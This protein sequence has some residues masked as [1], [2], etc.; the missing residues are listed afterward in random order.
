MKPRFG[1]VIAGPPGSGKTTYCQA[2]AE[3]FNNIERKT[4]VVNLDPANE[5]YVDAETGESLVD[6]PVID[7]SEIITLQN[8]VDSFGL[9]PNGGLLYCMQYLETN[10]DWLVQK[11]DELEDDTYVL[12]DIPGQVE[13]T[14]HDQSLQN[15]LKHLT[16]KKLNWRLCCVHLVDA[17][18]CVDPGRYISALIVSL[19][20]MIQLELPHINVLSKIDLMEG[21][22][23]LSFS[24]EYYTRAVDLSYI[25]ESLDNN[26]RTKKFSNLNKALC[27]IVEEFGLVGF[28]TLCIQ[29]KRS[30]VTLAHQIDNAIGYVDP[31]AG[32]GNAG[33]ASEA[34]QNAVSS[35]M[36]GQDELRRVEDL[37]LNKDF[38]VNQFNNNLDKDL[39]HELNEIPNL[40]NTKSVGEIKENW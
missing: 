30:M 3:L 37:Y 7:I 40:S 27:D 21:Y 4:A 1:Q 25:L 19:K 34:F 35:W 22:G 28:H 20:A 15:I 16:G 12:F 39:E 10:I 18:H 33:S 36:D 14:T 38:D 29:D 9:G 26:P 23:K 31:G 11:L 8:V 24:L 17:H 2:F 13:L 32:S 6:F 5:S